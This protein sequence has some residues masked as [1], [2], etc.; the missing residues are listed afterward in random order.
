MFEFLSSPFSL[1]ATGLA[2]LA[3]AIVLLVVWIVGL[4]RRIR[5]MADG[6]EAERRK[7]AEMQMIVSRR[8]QKQRSGR[9]GTPA[10][11]SYQWP[12]ADEEQAARERAQVERYAAQTMRG[13]RGA[14]RRDSQYETAPGVAEARERAAKMA[15]RQ[16]AARGE[17]EP[18]RPVTAMGP[19]RIPTDPNAARAQ[20]MRE[21]EARLEARRR[22]RAQEQ[23]AAQGSQR[24]RVSA[25]GEGRNNPR[26]RRTEAQGNPARVNGVDPAAQSQNPRAR[27]KARPV[28]GGQNASEGRPVRSR[29]DGPVPTSS[30]SASGRQSVPLQ[31]RQGRRPMTQQSN[32][33]PEPGDPI[34]V[35]AEAASSVGLFGRKKK[36]SSRG[37][38]AR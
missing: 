26:L 30:P 38:H 17:A 28:S 34:S 6:L 25:V 19:E 1:V 9:R 16:Q 24:N 37:K 21:R 20:A 35:Q 11:A 13:A 12:T 23:A 4:D 8:G 5:G 33:Q 14:S 7:V 22:A 31:P 18:E 3:V 27:Q 15:A 2:V 36:D 32:R 29:E 10:Q